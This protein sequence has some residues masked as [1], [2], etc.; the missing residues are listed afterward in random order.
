M[1]KKGIDI[2]CFQPNV[3][4]KKVKASGIDFVILRAGYGKER[5]QK[6]ETF[7]KHYA[8]AKKAGLNV[9]AY[10][11]SYAESNGEAETEAKVCIDCIKGKK[12]EYPIFFDLEE[13]SQLSKGRTFCDGIVK[14]FCGELEKA[15]YFAGLYISRSPLQ[16]NIS[17]DVAKRYALWVAEYGDKLNYSGNYG[18][19]QYTSCG[20]VNGINAKIDMDYSYVDYPKIIKE[21]HL[22]GY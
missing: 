22:N 13:K 14:T 8:D 11:Y 15:G 21:A 5:S 7:E 17:S 4:F 10:W 19:W 9:G 18:M 6:D 16:S 2:S 1:I 20:T 3:D 12:F